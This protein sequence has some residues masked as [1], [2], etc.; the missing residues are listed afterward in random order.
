MVSG[1]CVRHK[2]GHLQQA[3]AH[4]GEH[5]SLQLLA[6]DLLSQ[7]QIGTTVVWTEFTLQD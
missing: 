4:E 5:G 3:P 7:P 1:V 2:M 6:A